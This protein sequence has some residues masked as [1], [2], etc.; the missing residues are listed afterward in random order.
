MLLQS[1]TLHRDPKNLETADGENRRSENIEE[2]QEVCAG[3]GCGKTRKH[4][5]KLTEE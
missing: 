2:I 3:K 5:R 4:S 1:D